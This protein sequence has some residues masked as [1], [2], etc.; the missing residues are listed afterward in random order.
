MKKTFFILIVFF[1]SLSFTNLFGQHDKA[2]KSTMMSLQFIDSLK[3]RKN[4]KSEH[5]HVYPNKY[6]LIDLDNDNKFEIIEVVNKL[7]DNAPGFLPVELSQAFDFHEIYYYEEHNDLYVKANTSK[8]EFYNLKRKAFYETW[9]NQFKKPENL[10]SVLKEVVNSNR[11]LFINE[12]KRL[13][14]S[15]DK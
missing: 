11:E 12:I 4:V 13:I 5:Y 15:V 7:E 2:A 14:A 6:F 9:L 10:N 1:T 3:K 8:F